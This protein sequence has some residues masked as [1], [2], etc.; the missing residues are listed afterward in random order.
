[1]KRVILT[2]SILSFSCVFSSTLEEPPVWQYFKESTQSQ[3]RDIAS[4]N[5]KA[6]NI[7]NKQS[8]ILDA[9][10]LKSRLSISTQNNLSPGSAKVVVEKEI[11]LPLPNGDFVRVK[12]IDSPILSAD[13]AERYPDIK[14]WRIIGVDDPAITGRID[15]TSNGFHGILTL[16]NGDSVFIDP[17]KKQ[18]GNVYQT[19]SKKQNKSHFHNDFNCQVHD[20][21]TINSSELLKQPAAKILASSPALNLKTYRLAVAGTAEYTASQGGT[22]SSAYASMVTTINRVNQIYQRDIGISLQLVSGEQL[23]YTNPATDPYTNNNANALVSENMANMNAN[24]GVANFDVGHVFAQGALGGLAFVG[25]AC[26]NNANTPSGLVNAVKAGGATGTSNPQGEIFSI[27]Y[28]AHEIGH[29]LGASHTFNST[30]NGCGGANRTAETAVEPGSGSS[31]MS[32]SG[33][34]GTDDLQYNSDAAFHFASISQINSYTRDDTGNT[35]GS[36]SSTGNQNPVANAGADIIIPANT[37][38]ILDGSSTGGSSFSWDQTD[39]GSASAVDVDT[40]NNAIIRTLLPSAEEDRYIP[41]LS[42]LFSGTNTIGEKL[43]QTTRE[44]NFAYVVRDGLGGIGFD[45]KKINVTDTQSTFSIVSQSS[46]ETLLTGQSIKVLWNTANTN[47]A[48]VNCNTVDIQLLR[49][50]G[51]KNMLL[52]VTNNDGN[53]DLVIPAVTPTMSGARI[54]VGCSDNSFFNIGTGN[55]T[56]QQG[57][58]DTTAPVITV[59]GANPVNISQGSVYS[60][61][62]AIAVDNVDGTVTVSVSGAVNTA[63]AGGYTITYTAT[64]AVGNSATATRTVN[65]TPVAD[66]TP[67]VITLNGATVIN[68]VVG[69]TYTELGAT[70]LDNF[71]GTVAVSTT[72]MVNTAIAG[73]YIITYSAT[74][75]AGNDS[76]KTRTINLTA[77]PLDTVPPIIKFIGSGSVDVVVGTTYTDAGA[78][79]TDAIDGAIAVTSSGTVNTNII[80]SYTITYSAEDSSGNTA[81]VSRI[82]NVTAAP[83]LTPDTQAPTITLNGASTVSVEKGTAYIEFGA[84]AFDDRD[85][86]VNVIISGIVNTSTI[87]IY[88]IVYRATDSTGNTATKTR[89]VNVTNVPDTTAPVITLTGATTI[90]LQVGQEFNDPGFTAFDDHDGVIDVTITGLDAVDTSKVGEYKIIYS[91][92]DSSG[93]ITTEERTVV[94]EAVVNDEGSNSENS[95]KSDGGGG[96]FGFYLLPLMLLIGLR[97]QRVLYVSAK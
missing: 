15:F 75:A 80:G 56:V 73:L 40:G 62:G 8:L 7:I 71:D 65:V 26:L 50:N 78:T 46:A 16:A 34:C 42:D 44:L 37:P 96:S 95:L 48:P 19:L 35:C 68:L 28:V 81:S 36:D 49:S 69:A 52:P 3:L 63:V 32:Y 9:E 87:G 10:L 51:V 54:M 60:D 24:F 1:M 79:A 2:L 88:T 61:A 18:A 6:T 21:H 20:G 41:R 33:L 94:F 58:A 90:T 64:D 17:D 45:S 53:Q 13:M 55:I 4:K 66:T 82:V 5:I 57:V 39:T 72:G 11:D 47:T 43:P 85:G 93:N 22:K 70:A 38:F 23:I 12:A 59:T 92:V 76:S 30:K 84:S 86:G 67:P 89:T 14:T 27:E 83:T 25:V 91:A 97:R 74:D 77:A 29:Q 31:I